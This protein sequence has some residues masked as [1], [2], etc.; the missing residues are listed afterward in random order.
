MS[1]PHPIYAHVSYY[2]HI[3]S[4]QLRNFFSKVTHQQFHAKQPAYSMEQSPCEASI[5]S[6]AQEITQPEGLLPYSQDPTTSPNLV[7]YKFIPHLH[8]LFL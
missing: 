6:A 5:H 4:P 7:S 1:C 2:L 3:L 8:I